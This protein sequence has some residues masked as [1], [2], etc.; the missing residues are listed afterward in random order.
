MP[1]QSDPDMTWVYCDNECPPAWKWRLQHAFLA[2][3]LQCPGDFRDNHQQPEGI[4]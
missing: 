4:Q 3:E 1:A 2:E